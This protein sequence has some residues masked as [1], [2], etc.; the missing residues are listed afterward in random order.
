MDL[1]AGY[2]DPAA[3][4]T[5]SRRI[6]SVGRLDTEVQFSDALRNLA[7]AA[8]AA[9]AATR[10]RAHAYCADFSRLAEPR[11]KAKGFAKRMATAALKIYI[12][13]SF[14]VDR[15][16]FR[17]GKMLQRLTQDAV[18]LNLTE[19]CSIFR[20]VTCALLDHRVELICIIITF[21]LR[22][23]LTAHAIAVP[24]NVYCC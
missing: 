11:H 14:A 15:W 6:R 23:E 12:R 22:G 20:R 9:A 8:A 10:L 17:V 1:T 3:A 24:V 4:Q 7:V 13:A 19:I 2:S 21:D 18:V 5:M 16:E